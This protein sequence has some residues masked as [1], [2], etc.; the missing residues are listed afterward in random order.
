MP[1]FDPNYDNTI[2]LN[3]AAKLTKKFRDDFPGAIKANAYNK[4]QML[5]LLNQEGCKGFRIYNG[6]SVTGVQQMVIVGVD[7]D[8]NDLVDG[9]LLDHSQP[10]PEI[11][12]NANAL[13]SNT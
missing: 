7:V 6:L 12:S 9:M 3:D 11:C 13:N 8:G 5:D 4:S 10:C 1:S 2:S